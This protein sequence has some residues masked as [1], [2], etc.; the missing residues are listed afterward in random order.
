MTVTD[1]D[2]DG[3]YRRGL[4]ELVTQGDRSGYPLARPMRARTWLKR[5]SA[6]LAFAG[7]VGFMLLAYVAGHRPAETTPVTSGAST[8]GAAAQQPA[9]TA[10][11]VLCSSLTH[12][13]V[14]PHAYTLEPPAGARAAVSCAAAVRTAE[15][16]CPLN[17]RPCTTAPMPQVS[18]LSLIKDYPDLARFGYNPNPRLV[19]AVTWTSQGCGLPPGLS[20]ATHPSKAVGQEGDNWWLTASRVDST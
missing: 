6:T 18:E 16:A 5:A 3:I 7:V 1:R 19:W 4:H 12:V 17:S 13:E 8:G 9:T 11:S 10:S 2:L 20:I 15:A 14:F